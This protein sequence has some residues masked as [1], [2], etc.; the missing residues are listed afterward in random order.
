MSAPTGGE[1]IVHR[2]VVRVTRRGGWSWGPAP[3]SLV[4]LVLD[5]LPDLLATRFDEQ[6][7]GEGPDLEITDPVVLQVHLGRSLGRSSPADIVVEPPLAAFAA[8]PVELVES[9]SVVAEGEHSPPTPAMLLAELAERGELASLLALLP[10]ESLRLFV[11]AALVDDPPAAV[12][13]ALV[14][15]LAGRLS[16][17][18]PP[19]SAALASLVDSLPAAVVAAAESPVEVVEAAGETRV[20]SVLPFLLAG[21]LA[22]TGYLDAIGPALAAAGLLVEA[23]LFAAALAYK[24]L[25]ARGYGAAATF[26]GLEVIPDLAGFASRVAPVLPALD[27]VLALSLCRGH[28]RADPLLITGVADGLLLVDAQGMFP[29]AWSPSVEGLLPHWTACGWPAVLVCDSPL[30][31]SCLRDLVAAGVPFLTDV[32]PLRDDPVSRLTWR[33][34][35]W[36]SGTPSLRLAAEFPGYAE[37]LDGVVRALF[38]GDGPLDRSVALAASLSL[39]MIAWTLWHDRETTDPVLALTRFADLEATVQFTPAAVRV[40]IP[41]GRR[42]TDLSQS[43]LLAD[44]PDVVW[45]GG[46]TLTFSGG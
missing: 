19:P 17:P 22:R 8:T 36:T 30:P 35:L 20:S 18:S 4:R 11:T 7:T 16:L 24:V 23:P 43:G 39:G 9:P 21:P 2:C 3:D 10:G 6:L 25:G 45:L 41:L 28:D 46:R 27:G 15:E 40:R 32:R 14:T 44:V 31:P 42:H 29:I 12:V 13:E 38:V 26:A 33:T 1:I 5:T 34:P 37:R